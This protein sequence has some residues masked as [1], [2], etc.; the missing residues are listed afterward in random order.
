MENLLKLSRISQELQC[1][2][3]IGIRRWCNEIFF[4]FEV[5]YNVEKSESILGALAEWRLSHLSKD[6]KRLAKDGLVEFVFD[7]GAF[8]ISVPFGE[9]DAYR[10]A[11]KF[12]IQ[13]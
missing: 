9:L 7:D 10:I 13:M 12:H 11:D 2:D 8:I 3:H 1:A 6:L 4:A 5:S